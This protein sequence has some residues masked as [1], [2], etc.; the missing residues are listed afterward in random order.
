MKDKI[1][2]NEYITILFMCLTSPFLGMGIYNLLKISKVDSTISIIISYFITLILLFIFIKIVNFKPNLNLKEKINILFKKNTSRI[3]IIL[4]CSLFFIMASTLSYSINSF[5]IS[6]FLSETPILFVSII[7]GILIIYINSKG[8]EVISRVSFVLFFLSIILILVAVFGNYGKADISNLKPLFQNDVMT[9]IKGSIYTVLLNSIYL[10]TLLIIPKNMIKN[11]RSFNK[12]LIITCSICF[13]IFLI[14]IIYILI[15]LGIDLAILYHYPGYIIMKEISIFS[16]I[17]KIENFIIIHW[18][19]EA[20][21]TLS[22]I[23]YFISKMTNIKHYIIVISNI[24]LYSIFFYNSTF[25]NDFVTKYIPI[26]SSLI[27]FIILA[28][29]IKIKKWKTTL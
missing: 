28:I 19:F 6:Q 5:I 8:F 1:S 13:L 15:I 25:F 29:Y 14:I 27:L 7:M 24:I 4:L 11:N 18:V 2:L 12:W 23:T 26:I 20:F 10:F 17:D 9:I 21:I 3:I 16:F 22:M